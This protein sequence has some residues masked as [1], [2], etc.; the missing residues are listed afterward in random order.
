M[1]KQDFIDWKQHPV[2]NAFIKAIVDKREG[3]REEL[4]FSAGSN[5]VE[6]AVK[7]GAILTCTDILN[8]EYSE[9]GNVE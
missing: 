9:L 1:T 5:S 4:G 2:T 3:L 6:D 7:R 8:M